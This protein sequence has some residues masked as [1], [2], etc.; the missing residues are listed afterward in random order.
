MQPSRQLS[1][2]P[3]VGPKDREEE[4]GTGG[5]GGAERRDRTFAG[6]EILKL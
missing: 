4:E 5:V 1:G 2:Q 3:T 6:P